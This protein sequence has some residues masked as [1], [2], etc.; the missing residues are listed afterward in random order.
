MWLPAV[1][2]E[3]TSRSGDV[4]VGQPARKQYEDLDFPGGETGR[5]FAAARDAVAGGAENRLDRICIKAAGLDVGVELGGRLGGGALGAVGTRLAHR[6]VG[7]GGGED[8]SR[9]RDRGA[10]E[11]ARVARAVEALPVL[12]GDRAERREDR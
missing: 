2:G 1:L 3:I 9:A 6:L 10:G 4:L 11:A 5:P 7:V 8:S 12:H